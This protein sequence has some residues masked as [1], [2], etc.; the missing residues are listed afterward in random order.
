MP[1]S[2]VNSLSWVRSESMYSGQLAKVS[3]PLLFLP[4]QKSSPGASW[5]PWPR[6]PHADRASASAEAPSTVRRV[7]RVRVSP[8]RRA[9]S[10]LLTASALFGAGRRWGMDGAA[11]SAGQHVGLV[12][13]PGEPDPVA[14]AR[15][16]GRPCGVLLVH[17][18]LG[19]SVAVHRHRVVGGR[20]EVDHLGDGAGQLGAAGLGAAV[21]LGGQA[22]KRV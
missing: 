21:R 9:G 2:S 6:T 4:S 22:R 10:L 1:V 20:T 16:P 18:E 17:G 3:F 8:R 15:G 11:G 5:A 19:A 7:G 14:A 12:R 13:S